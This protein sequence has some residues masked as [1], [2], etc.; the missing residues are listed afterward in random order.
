MFK[1]MEQQ[2]NYNRHPYMPTKNDIVSDQAL[3][4]PLLQ[5]G[6]GTTALH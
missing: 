3:V 4:N 5:P 2:N 6:V 1:Q